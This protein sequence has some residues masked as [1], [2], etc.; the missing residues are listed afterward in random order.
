MTTDPNNLTN[1]FRVNS[2]TARGQY[3]S[4]PTAGLT[5]ELTR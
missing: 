4:A 1:P 5:Y 2:L 3:G